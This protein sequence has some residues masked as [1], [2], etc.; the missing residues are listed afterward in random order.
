MKKSNLFLAMIALF[1]IS[2]ISISCSKEKCLING[3]WTFEKMTKEP[4]PFNDPAF[5]DFTIELKKDG[6]FLNNNVLIGTF[7]IENGNIY[8]NENLYGS[9]FTCSK[10]NLKFSSI[11]NAMETITFYY[12]R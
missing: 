3:V 8:L 9:N 5:L 1:I 12:K 6:S 7:K 11:N 10:N 2:S 4:V